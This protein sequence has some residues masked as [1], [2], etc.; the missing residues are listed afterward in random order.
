MKEYHNPKGREGI[1]S[2]IKYCSRIK[3]RKK[4]GLCYKYADFNVW[5][6]DWNWYYL[7]T[8]WDQTWYY[9]EHSHF[10]VYVPKYKPYPPSLPSNY[11]NTGLKDFE[12]KTLLKKGC[13]NN[14]KCKC[15]SIVQRAFWYCSDCYKLIGEM[16]KMES[17]YP[18][19]IMLSN[20]LDRDELKAKI[21]I[22][23]LSGSIQF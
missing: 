1:G 22:L 15:M 16:A 11:R 23:R 10:R 4:C 6:K 13:R 5:S 3:G 20:K 2:D 7:L 14:K 19:D 18:H 17:V 8:W 12:I 9:Q 21:L